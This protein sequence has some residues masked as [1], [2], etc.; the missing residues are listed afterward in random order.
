MTRLEVLSM[1]QALDELQ[2]QN[3]QQVISDYDLGTKA[4][5][6]VN[7]TADS[8]DSVVKPLRKAEQAYMVKLQGL[9]D[10]LKSKETKEAEKAKLRREVKELQET[11]QKDREELLEETEK[12]VKIHQVDL[13]KFSPSCR[14][15]AF[16]VLDTLRDMLLCEAADDA[17]YSISIGDALEVRR[18][19]SLYLYAPSLG[20]LHQAKKADEEVDPEKR[21]P[22]NVGWE[23]GSKL[24]WNAESIRRAVEPFSDELEA[25]RKL[26]KDPPGKKGKKTESTEP[27]KET[28]T[29]EQLDAWVDQK[30]EEVIEV[31]GLRSIKLEEFPEDLGTP[32]GA[33]FKGLLPIIESE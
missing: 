32:V 12:D 33:V 10:K 11:F 24:F 30:L 27:D 7:V 26:L 21:F 18:A 3:A 1:Y 22:V 29:Q 25:K 8:F 23:F 2:P 14:V 9:Q 28:I 5:Y 19:I 16:W 17:T 20:Q 15:P 13:A 6:A 4:A 31:K